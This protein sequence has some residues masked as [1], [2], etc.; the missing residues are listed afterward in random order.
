MRRRG[1]LGELRCGLPAQTEQLGP[2]DAGEEHDSRSAD[3]QEDYE[4]GNCGSHGPT[5]ATALAGRHLCSG[6]VTG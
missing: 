4:Q 2:Q 3:E 5:N 6:P 1:A